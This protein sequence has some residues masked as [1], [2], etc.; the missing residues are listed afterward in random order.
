MK[1]RYGVG[2]A[3]ASG[4]MFGLIPVA[5]KK[6]TSYY[7]ISVYTG[8]LFRYLIGAGFL[9]VPGIMGLLRWR[10][11]RREVGAV[12]LDAFLCVLTSVFLYG[13]Y[14]RIPTGI[15]GT[16]H[17]LYPLFVILGSAVLFHKPLQKRI[18]GAAMISFA[19]MVLLCSPQGGQGDVMGVAMAL[20]SAVC[21]GG[22][23]LWMGEKGL[24]EKAP[25]AFSFLLNGFGAGYLFFYWAALDRPP[26][27]GFGVLLLC[28]LPAGAFAMLAYL[29]LSMAMKGIGAVRTSVLGTMEPVASLAAGALVL[30][31]RITL[32]AVAGCGLILIAAILV[33]KKEGEPE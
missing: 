2:Y 28:F 10:P 23:L 17:Y 27:P 31:E 4:V 8:L 29:T 6:V 15:A 25:A 11:Q 1:Q 13:S 32:S 12:A 14:A 24:G 9:A 3:M 22:Y 18:L 21:F 5:V 19:G 26:E 7:G 16:I 20:M 30:G 33:L